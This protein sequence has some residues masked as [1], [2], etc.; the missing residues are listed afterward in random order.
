M[1]V[2]IFEDWLKEPDKWARTGPQEV[3]DTETGEIAWLFERQWWESLRLAHE[4]E[5]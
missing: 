4:E 5:A 1:Q 2:V 3:T